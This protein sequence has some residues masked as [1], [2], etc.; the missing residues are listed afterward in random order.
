M[1]ITLSNILYHGSIDNAQ[2]IFENGFAPRI[3]LDGTFV[4][5]DLAAAKNAIQAGRI[6]QFDLMRLHE[7]LQGVARQNSG[8]I[9]FQSSNFN[10]LT[11]IQR[12]L[13][14]PGNLL[15]QQYLHDYTGFYPYGGPWTQ[16][17][18]ITP[19]DYQIMNEAERW[20]VFPGIR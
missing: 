11:A 15:I 12:E 18:L 17:P 16:I 1:F 2:A 5:P 20:I 9:A 19:S 6:G 3:A 14:D 10:E 8:I 7:E 4:T 13:A